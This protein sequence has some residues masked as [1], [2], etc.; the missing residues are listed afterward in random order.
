MR[1]VKYEMHFYSMYDYTGIRKHLEK[2]AAKGWMLEKTGTFAWKYR[3]IEP[4]KLHFAINYFPKASEFAP[5]PTEE[6]QTM[7]DYCEQAG[8]KLVSTVAQMQIFCN[9]QENPVPLETDAVTQ[10]EII[11]K[12]MKSS[13][14]PAQIFLGILGLVQMGMFLVRYFEHPISVLTEGMNLF[15]G[16]CWIGVIAL[17]GMEFIN[18]FTW[19]RKARIAAEE[20]GRFVETR[21]FPRVQIAVLVIVFGGLMFTGLASANV[22]GITTTI[23]TVVYVTVLFAGVNLMKRFLKSRKV[24]TGVN[25]TITIVTSFVLSFAMMFLGV[26]FVMNTIRN[27]MGKQSGAE[28]YEYRGMTWEI[29]HDELPLTLEDFV[30]VDYDEYS[31]QLEVNDTFLAAEYEAT[32]RPKMDALEYPD[33]E[34]RIVKVKVPLFYEMC[35]KEMLE[36]V[37][38]WRNASGYV[39]EQYRDQYKPIDAGIWQADAAYREY[40]G[41]EPQNRFLIC[42]RDKIAEISFYTFEDGIQEGW[43]TIVAEKLKDY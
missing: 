29:Y 3:R 10:V 35:K 4:K 19:L 23:F 8:W 39:D 16:L 2:M 12:A 34:Y 22:A 26:R 38:H 31:Y 11:A 5:G 32:Q 28:T 37:E 1:N 41:D 30:D 27:V 24:S 42:W 6:Q 15:T 18:Y 33:L 20:E 9:E 43:F 21:S 40:I 36:E 13:F 17:T 7:F 14:L 25:R